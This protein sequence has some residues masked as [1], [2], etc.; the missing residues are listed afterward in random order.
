MESAPAERLTEHSFLDELGEQTVTDPD[1]SLVWSAHLGVIVLSTLPDAP[2]GA[3]DASR[4][5]DTCLPWISSKLHK[6]I[7]LILESTLLTHRIA[8]GLFYG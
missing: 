6:A 8:N 2:H 5:G 3:N 4:D 1:P 7:V